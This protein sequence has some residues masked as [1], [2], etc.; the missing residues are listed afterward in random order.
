[1]RRLRIQKDQPDSPAGFPVGVCFIRSTTESETVAW[2]KTEGDARIFAN[3][4]EKIAEL[5]LK[6]KKEAQR[7]LSEVSTAYR[8]ALILR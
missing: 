8:H 6:L 2:F 4:E 1:M 5:E 7:R 3:A